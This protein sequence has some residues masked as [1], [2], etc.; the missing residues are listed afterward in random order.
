LLITLPITL[1][2]T[3]PT[4]ILPPVEQQPPRVFS[5]SDLQ[6]LIRPRPVLAESPVTLAPPPPGWATSRSV[7]R[8]DINAAKR[9]ESCAGLS[10]DV[11]EQYGERI[12]REDLPNP[13]LG[14]PQ[15]YP[16]MMSYFEMYDEDE[17]KQA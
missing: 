4:L 3:L 7:A 2:T 10:P 6:E 9:V 11:A 16:A 1:P 14:F 12:I 8:V 13:M 5:S 15:L 17:K